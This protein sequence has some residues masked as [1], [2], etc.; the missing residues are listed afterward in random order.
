MRILITILFVSLIAACSRP[1]AE[2]VVPQGG[3]TAPASVQF[4]NKSENAEEYEWIFDDGN[5]SVKKD[6]THRYISSGNYNVTLIATKGNKSSK[7]EK[8]VFVEAPK[9]CLVEL[10]TKFGTMLIELSDDTPQHRDNFIKLVENG[11][12]NDL[13]FHR[14]ING[15]MIQGGDPNSKDPKPG[16]QLGTGGPGYEIP[17][18]IKQDLAHIKGALAAARKG[19]MVNPQKKSSGSQFY[20]VQGREL[21][22]RDLQQNEFRLGYSY[23]DEI[24]QTYLEQGGT[25]F[26]DGEYTVFGRVIAGIEII[27]SIAN[28]QTLRGDR[29]S[30]DVKMKMTSIK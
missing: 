11:F 30:D 20:I 16:I 26:L 8:R 5:T 27:D 18:E 28:V 17:A 1:I 25:P 21:S 9:K 10:E 7:T 19:D 14:V 15:F 23:S 6:P 2:F 24:K 13:L 4:E 3:L 29:P 22:E 12:Y